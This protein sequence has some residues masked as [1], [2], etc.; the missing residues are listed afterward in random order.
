MVNEETI[1]TGNAQQGKSSEG[2]L[3]NIV[4]KTWK[5]VTIGGTAGILLG[6][7]A[8]LA[9]HTI[10]L[11]ADAKSSAPADDVMNK[12]TP[13]PVEEKVAEEAIIE[14]Q[15]ALR[16]AT[17]SDD[18]TF[19]QAFTQAREMVGPGGVFHWHGAIFSTY[20][21]DEWDEMTDEERDHFAESVRPEVDASQVD[22]EQ[23]ASVDDDIEPDSDIDDEGGEVFADVEVDQNQVA[24]QDVADVPVHEAN[25]EFIQADIREAEGGFALADEV[26]EDVVIADNDEMVQDIAMI[27]EEFN[28][29]IAVAEDMAVA[30]DLAVAEDVAVTEDIEVAEDVAVADED[31]AAADDSFA[32][33]EMFNLKAEDD[34]AMANGTKSSP[35]AAHHDKFED[36][37]SDDVVRIVGYGE[38]DGHAVRGLDLDGDLIAD[39]AVIDVDDS[40]D[41]SRDDIVVEEGNGN[42]TT[43]GEL[44]D[45]AMNQLQGAHDDAHDNMPNPDVAEDMPDYMDDAIAQL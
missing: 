1:Y 23:L 37:I 8:L 26:D 13:S 6:A 39:V 40:G 3:Q 25:E 15:T 14:D 17:V 11:N 9:Q 24:D 4:G 42:M 10:A 28:E 30:E 33:D 32:L 44:H 18:L 35:D 16:V 45:F 38:F 7:G 27:D 41:L 34:V 29:D 43:Y 12:V 5:P 31:A 36:F 2:A 22:A 21:A 20:T 19:E